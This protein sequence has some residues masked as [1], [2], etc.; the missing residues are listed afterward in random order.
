MQFCSKE[1]MS[2]LTRGLSRLLQH[3]QGGMLMEEKAKS[4]KSKS[5]VPF[6]LIGLGVGAAFGGI[7]I[8]A[9]SVIGAILDNIDDE[10]FFE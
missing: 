2:K 7:G 10:E 5:N 4:K 1:W 9:G 8:I 6:T 3:S